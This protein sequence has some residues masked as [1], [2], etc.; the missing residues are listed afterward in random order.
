MFVPQPRAQIQ[1]PPCPLQPPGR[2]L[3]TPPWLQ[4]QRPL[5]GHFPWL[6]AWA[7]A[8]PLPFPLCHQ[9][10]GGDTRT[11]PA[12][13]DAVRAPLPRMLTPRGNSG[14][15]SPLTPAPGNTCAPACVFV[16]SFNDSFFLE[17]DPEK[18]TEDH[19]PS[20]VRKI[21]LYA[22]LGGRETLKLKVILCILI[23]LLSI[24]STFFPTE[25][26]GEDEPGKARRQ[27][28]IL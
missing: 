28:V 6:Q 2:R 13:V 12:D 16:N 4:Y 3:R 7:S 10:E 1:A 23:H 27:H 15:S 11:R 26:T 20:K 24:T 19:V 18:I 22:D 9:L 8:S 17:A 5:D 21:K 14:T 25:V